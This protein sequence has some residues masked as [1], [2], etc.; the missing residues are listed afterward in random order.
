LRLPRE[1][2]CLAFEQTIRAT[3]EIPDAELQRSLQALAC[4][5]FKILKKHPPSRDVAT[6]DSFSF[7]DSFTS[8]LQKIKNGQ[9]SSRIET[10]EERQETKDR[11]DEERRHQ[12]EVCFCH[13]DLKKL[14]DNLEGLHR[15]RD[16]RP[17]NPFSQL[18]GQRGDQ[19]AFFA[20]SC[21]ASR[22]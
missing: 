5:K 13:G 12:I 8:P 4:A 15:P 2:L 20:V 22:D 7:N 3:T 1:S 19:A 17:Q 16:E 9:I 10:N 14:S 6:T 21:A 11:V 18:V